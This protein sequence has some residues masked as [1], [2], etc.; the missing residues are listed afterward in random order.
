MLTV[1][2]VMSEEVTSEES[3]LSPEDLAAA[4]DKMIEVALTAAPSVERLK[5]RPDEA[6]PRGSGEAA[7]LQSGAP[8]TR[9]GWTRRP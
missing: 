7:T 1:S 4:V 8:D 9:A 5:H 3:Y 2:D 6:A